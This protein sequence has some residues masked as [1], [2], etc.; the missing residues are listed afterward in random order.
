MGF[1]VG[2][3]GCVLETLFENLVELEFC[4]GVEALDGLFGVELVCAG[5]EGIE[6]CIEDLFGGDGHWMRIYGT[7]V[8]CN[9]G[10]DVGR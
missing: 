4:Q 1:S 9:C 10:A 2:A 6:G 7:G 8:A 3:Q 5:Y